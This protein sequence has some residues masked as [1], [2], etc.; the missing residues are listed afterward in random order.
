MKTYKP[1]QNQVQNTLYDV[2]Q[3][4]VPLALDYLTLNGGFF[5]RTD[6]VMDVKGQKHP[7]D[8]RRR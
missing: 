6:V 5:V 2:R 1:L 3:K 7:H 4:Q 8:V